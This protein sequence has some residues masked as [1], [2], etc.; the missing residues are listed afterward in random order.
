MLRA[1]DIR[2]GTIAYFEQGVLH[3]SPDVQAPEHLQ[4]DCTKL[5][6]F[7]CVS[8]DVGTHSSWT[9]L[10]T[11]RTRHVYVAL[12]PEHIVRGYGPMVDGT[13][14]VHGALY[15]GANHVFITASANEYPFKGGRPRV[16]PNG[17]EL[18]CLA[19]EER[20]RAERQVADRRAAL[21]PKGRFRQ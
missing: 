16:T 17:M 14:F 5:R 21:G 8:S 3:G 13:C 19:L 2:P 7:V 6:P 12:A 9:G 15:S 18:V 4:G 20:A 10:T 11:T 1:R